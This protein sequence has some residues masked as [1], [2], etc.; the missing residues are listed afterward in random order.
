[1][2]QGHAP[3][4]DDR[5]LP[6]DLAADLAPHLREALNHQLRRR[7][8][9]TLN[10]RSQPQTLAKLSLVDPGGGVSAVSYHL[11][12]LEGCGSVSVSPAP[13]GE[14]ESVWRYAS[15]V[16]SDRWVLSVLEATAQLDDL[17]D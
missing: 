5:P 16:S 17:D 8:L 3:I 9:R 15:N 1:M 4:S 11:R 12:V 2:Q 14:A 7:I 6:P 13:P 10:T